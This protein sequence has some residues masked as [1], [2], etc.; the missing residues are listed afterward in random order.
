M[1]ACFYT[2]YGSSFLHCAI[3]GA[4]RN[5]VFLFSEKAAAFYCQGIPSA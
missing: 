2:V 4:Y 5:M 1:P 3:P